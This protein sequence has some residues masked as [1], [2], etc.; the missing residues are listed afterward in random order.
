[1][2]KSAFIFNVYIFFSWNVSYIHK[3]PVTWS[4]ERTSELDRHDGVGWTDIS[5][6]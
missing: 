3:H 2:K 1:L 4:C 6:M 5:R